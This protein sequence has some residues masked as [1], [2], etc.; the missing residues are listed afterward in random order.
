ME[1][2]EDE[3]EGSGDRGGRLVEDAAEDSKRSDEGAG[4]GRNSDEYE[5]SGK[6]DAAAKIEDSNPPRRGEEEVDDTMYR[7]AKGLSFDST[8]EGKEEEE[9]EEEEEG[10]EADAEEQAQAVQ[11][12]IEIERSSTKRH[13]EKS[14]SNQFSGDLGYADEKDAKKGEDVAAIRRHIR[15]K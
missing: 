9:E 4:S 13:P 7:R 6:E 5:V 12:A 1:Y 8:E 3:G 2:K 14:K 11:H 10:K 15:E